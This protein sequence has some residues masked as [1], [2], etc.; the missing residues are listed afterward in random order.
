MACG[1]QDTISR[2]YLSGADGKG[3][4]REIRLRRAL[5][6]PWL[7][8]CLPF[9]TS[10]LVLSPSRMNSYKMQKIVKLVAESPCSMLFDELF[11]ETF[12][13][14][15]SKHQPSFILALK[16]KEEGNLGESCAGSHAGY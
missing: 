15:V 1:L 7:R 3:G 9:S 14:F 10:D 11:P 12:P 6:D 5:G 8:F 2:M 4:A 16:A 13:M